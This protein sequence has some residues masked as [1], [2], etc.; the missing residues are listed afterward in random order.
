MY[1]VVLMVALSGSAETV[2]FGHR[3]H[4]CH[5]SCHAVATCGG[6]GGCHVRHHRHRH[7]CCA[8]ACC[9]PVTTCCAP[10]SYGCDGGMAPM[11]PG[12]PAVA[13][14][15]AKAMPAPM[16][17]PTPPKTT[18]VIDPVQSPVAPVEYVTYTT[19]QPVAYYVSYRR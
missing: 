8:P 3:C 14:P 7:G 15:P 18:Q 17:A 10:V 6:C 13:P 2:D 4:G 9:A 16:P 1:S 19:A 5:S 12:G 11:A